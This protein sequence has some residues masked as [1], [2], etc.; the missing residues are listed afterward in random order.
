MFQESLTFEGVRASLG[1]VTRETDGTAPPPT[2]S[3]VGEAGQPLETSAP[4]LQGAVVVLG[5]CWHE[6]W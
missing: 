2:P 3:P 6:G 4:D 1:R 5:R